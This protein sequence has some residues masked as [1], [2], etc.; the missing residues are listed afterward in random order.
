MS[1]VSTAVC[2]HI[3]QTVNLMLHNPVD[4]TVIVNSWKSASVN[5]LKYGKCLICFDQRTF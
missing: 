5:F 4:A 2:V 1:T 3:H